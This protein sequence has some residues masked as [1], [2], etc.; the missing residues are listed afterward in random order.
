MEG[1]KEIIRDI[2]DFPKEGVIF[3]D[4]APLL[5]DPVQFGRVIDALTERYA[6]KNIAKVVGIEARG[7]LFAGALAH[8]LRAGCVMLRKPGKLPYKTYQQSYQLEYGT[9]AIEI[10]Q[11]ALGDGENVVLIDDVL[12]TGGTM[13]A[14]VELVQKNFKAN[15]V[16][17]AFLIELDFL[18]GRDKLK[19]VPIHS[20]LHY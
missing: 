9:D 1:L 12:A 14:A 10:H 16:E 5:G 17:V 20:L 7:F 19:N 18:K 8:E 11:D 15:I 2:P 3:K 6:A 13:A 4:I